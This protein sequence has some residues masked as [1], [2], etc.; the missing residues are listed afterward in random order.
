MLELESKLFLAE[1]LD[2]CSISF[3]SCVSVVE[4]TIL[5]SHRKLECVYYKEE[6]ELSELLQVDSMMK[7]KDSETHEFIL[8]QLSE[9]SLEEKFIPKFSHLGNL[10]HF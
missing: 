3:I 10:S 7:E 6:V 9:I 4:F 5:S 1:E 8:E 2:S